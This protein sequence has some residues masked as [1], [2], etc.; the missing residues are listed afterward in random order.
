MWMADGQQ[1]ACNMMFD[2]YFIGYSRAASTS[3]ELAF[4]NHP[5]I[6]ISQKMRT[7]IRNGLYPNR[8]LEALAFYK[9]DDRIRIE[10]D[11]EVIGN[12]LMGDYRLIL[13]RAKS[14]NNN[15]KV[16]ISL[17]NQK[18]RILSEYKNIA[19][20]DNSQYLT[21]KK[22]LKT[23]RGYTVIK[24]A[25]YYERI[26]KIYKIISSDNVHIII[27]EKLVKMPFLN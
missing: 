16:V 7:F 5:N 8:I 17:R 2:V 18:S 1:M 3:I 25:N 9:K 6:Q 14:Y 27:F 20:S 23:Y 24:S 12:D 19:L 10:C 22:W 15:L 26:E 4:Y 11:E 13:E 21:F